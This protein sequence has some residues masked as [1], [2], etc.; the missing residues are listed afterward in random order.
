[1][2]AFCSSQALPAGW[3]KAPEPSLNDQSQGSISVLLLDLYCGAGGAAMGYSRA[4]FE[5][6]GV[7]I[8]PMPNYPFDFIQ[9]DAIEFMRALVRDRGSAFDAIHA[10]PPCQ[11]YSVTTAQYRN[12]GRQYPDLVA[13]TR[14]LL[15]ETGL[16]YVIENVPRAPLINP[17]VL[18]GTA[19]G[20][21]ANGM[22]I[23][24][25]RLFESNFR[26]PPVKCDH[27]GRAMDIMG[28]LAAMN[29]MRDA[30]GQTLA[31]RGGKSLV[32]IWAGLMGVDGW[33]TNDEARQSFPPA[34][35]EYIGGHLMDYLEPSLAA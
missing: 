3:K 1:M 20:L 22:H 29:R 34:Y 33:M 26:I 19:F 14:E 6:V 17:V 12:Q 13:P 15:R 9:A 32:T 30:F 25:H 10:S 2:I 23:R 11:L 24:R 5:V 27:A 21:F 7:D 28:D 16:P 8:E 4:G 18:C 31:D 35:T